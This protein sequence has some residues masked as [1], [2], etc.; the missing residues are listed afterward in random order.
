MSLVTHH[1]FTEAFGDACQN[2]DISSDWLSHNPPSEWTDADERLWQ[3]EE[4]MALEARQAEQLAKGYWW[5]LE[6]VRCATFGRDPHTNP[7]REEQ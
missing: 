4:R 2:L 6:G 3:E 7:Y 5:D 1:E